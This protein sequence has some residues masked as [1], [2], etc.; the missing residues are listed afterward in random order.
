MSQASE[1]FDA[2]V[3]AHIPI[4]GLIL[5]THHH[6]SDSR[7]PTAATHDSYLSVGKFHNFLVDKLTS[8][9]VDK[10]SAPYGLVSGQL[11]NL[12]TEIKQAYL[13]T[14]SPHPP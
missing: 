10:D 6:F 12:S 11:V 9:Q 8:Q 4:D 1:L 13:S 14:P 3:T 5:V 2:I 7:G